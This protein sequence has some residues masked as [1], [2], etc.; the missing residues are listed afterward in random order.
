MR[1]TSYL[2]FTTDWHHQSYE[3]I[4]LENKKETCT[5]EGERGTRKM[6]KKA[7]KTGGVVYLTDPTRILIEILSWADESYKIELFAVKTQIYNFEVK[8]SERRVVFKN[9]SQLLG[10]DIG[11]MCT[12]L[13]LKYKELA[14]WNRNGN[15][16]EEGVK[17]AKKTLKNNLT[18]LR[19]LMKITES[20]LSKVFLYWRYKSSLSSISVGIFM[21][22]CN[23][24]NL[25]IESTLELDSKIRPAYFGGRCEVFGNPYYKKEKIL[26]MDFNNMYGEILKQDLPTGNIK[27]EEAPKDVKKPGFYY[28]VLKSESRLPI[29]PHRK[30]TKLDSD[31]KEWDDE[32]I[33]EDI[34]FTNGEFEGLYYYEEL[35]F[36]QKK[37]GKILEIKYGE[38]FEGPKKS[39]FRDFST[40][41]IKLR[42]KDRNFIWK[43]LLVSFYGRLGM[44]PI[45]TKSV[46][47]NETE[48]KDFSE[49][50]EI[51][52][53]RWVNKHAIIE[54]KTED[55]K[56]KSLVQYAA[57]ITSLARIKLYKE[58]EKVEKEGGRLF[59]CDTDSIFA[60]YP[61]NFETEK[62]NVSWD[63]E[64]IEDAVFASTRSYSLKT[65]KSTWTTK[66]AGIER[67][68]IN[69]EQFKEKFYTDYLQPIYVDTYTNRKV[70]LTKEDWNQVKAINLR[71]YRKRIFSKDKKK[72]YSLIKIKEEYFQDSY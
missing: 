28:V 34:I 44:R 42:E 56:T 67:D 71:Q 49:K 33:D 19:T 32:K 62:S 12:K 66:I 54:I 58:I 20:K 61:T 57:A 55:T 68:S 65:S 59:Y 52:K 13:D 5:F 37:G 31:I 15:K 35:E 9:I 60:G 8:K 48:Y 25:K 23:F 3:I 36:F 30:L 14:F 72:T 21:E 24:F 50:N 45:R 38:V 46:I 63:N 18:S 17:E 6:L 43:K 70:R 53:E 22:N 47:I 51:L 2:E 41:I 27:R 1:N 69:F 40:L 29:L 7:L 64:S 16:G 11:E 26:H 39:I 4:L 10:G